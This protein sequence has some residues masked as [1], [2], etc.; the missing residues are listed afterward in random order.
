MVRTPLLLVV[1]G[2]PDYVNCFRIAYSIKVF[3]EGHYDGIESVIYESGFVSKTTFYK[4]F[5]KFTGK[6]PSQY[7]ADLD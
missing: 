3:Q 4:N 6:T 1:L 5:K 2:N 7:L